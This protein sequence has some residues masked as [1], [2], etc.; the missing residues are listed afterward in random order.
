[1]PKKKQPITH[2]VNLELSDELYK[3]SFKHG[4]RSQYIRDAIIEKHKRE[5]K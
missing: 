1:M 5:T 3:I 4:N 2:R